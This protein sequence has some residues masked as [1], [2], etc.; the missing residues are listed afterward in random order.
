M[1][2]SGLLALS[3]FG[4]VASFL[5]SIAWVCICVFE[6]KSFVKKADVYLYL[7]LN[8]KI[9]TAWMQAKKFARIIGI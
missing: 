7:T 4:L 1:P 3:I 6:E 8:T 2:K 5:C 9:M